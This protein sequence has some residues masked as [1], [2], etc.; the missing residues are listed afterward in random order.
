MDDFVVVV[1]VLP[2]KNNVKIKLYRVFE[3]LI[4]LLL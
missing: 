4:L 1:V 2:F 3:I